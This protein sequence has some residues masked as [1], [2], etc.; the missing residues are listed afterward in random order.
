M[1]AILSDV[2]EAA[3]SVGAAGRPSGQLQ[4]GTRSGNGSEE[5]VPEGGALLS[6]RLF[7][8]ELIVE[9]GFL[10]QYR[11]DFGAAGADG[12]C[13]AAVRARIQGPGDQR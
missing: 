2:Q 4:G 3:L 10:K 6:S 13:L 1:D 11:Y 12:R 7:A 8:V 9:W 5:D